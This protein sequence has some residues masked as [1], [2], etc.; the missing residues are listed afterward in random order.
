MDSG[1]VRNGW[2]GPSRAGDFTHPKTVG[3]LPVNPVRKLDYYP[4]STGTRGDTGPLNLGSP[5]SY[6]E[7]IRV[8]DGL[9]QHFYLLILINGD[10][11]I[12]AGV[13]I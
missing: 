11:F 4:N 1:S 6:L 3:G 10:G 2:N 12:Y 9:G 5:L 13:A 7:G 8:F